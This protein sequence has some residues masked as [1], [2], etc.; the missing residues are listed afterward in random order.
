MVDNRSAG[1]FGIGG[2]FNFKSGD[3][4][5]S[6]A[7]MSEDKMGQGGEYF[8]QGQSEDEQNQNNQPYVDRSSQLRATLNS[9]AMMNVASVL[10]SK[11]R[12]S[13]LDEKNEKNEVGSDDKKDKEENTNRDDDENEEFLDDFDENEE[14]EYY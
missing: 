13:F 4:S 10:N 6:A 8:S 11:R 1:H 14:D 2:A 9:M 5:G 12:L 3:I 7:K